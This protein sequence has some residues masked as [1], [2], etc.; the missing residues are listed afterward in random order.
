MVFLVFPLL[1]LV[2]FF[3]YDLFTSVSH[4]ISSN[5]IHSFKLLPFLHCIAQ[6]LLSCTLASTVAL[7]SLV[8]VG[9]PGPRWATPK[10]FMFPVEEYVR[11]KRHATIVDFRQFLSFSSVSLFFLPWFCSLL[12]VFAVVRRLFHVH[13]E[14]TEVYLGNSAL[15]KCAIPEYVRPYVR[16]ASWHRGEEILLPELSD[17]GECCHI[18]TETHR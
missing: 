8:A 17:V 7:F 5:F 2:S 4:V 12:A 15:I 10:R 16:V 14:N 13:V 3:L 18:F 1:P 6:L 9:F 11:P